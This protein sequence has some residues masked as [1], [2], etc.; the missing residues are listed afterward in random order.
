MTRHYYAENCVY[1]INSLSEDDTLL[2]FDSRAERDAWVAEDE[3]HRQAVTLSEERSR[4]SVEYFG[5][6]YWGG[7]PSEG[8]NAVGFRPSYRR[9]HSWQ[10]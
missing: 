3:E 6:D 10:D 2:R 9:A 1:G 7:K 5:R 8:A 4:Y